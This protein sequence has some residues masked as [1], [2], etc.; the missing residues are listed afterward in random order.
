MSDTSKFPCSEY[1]GDNREL[2]VEPS[3]DK[4]LYVSVRYSDQIQSH[5]WLSPAESMRLVRTINRMKN[6]GVIA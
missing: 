3:V 1:T 6:D 5:I 4:K 2:C